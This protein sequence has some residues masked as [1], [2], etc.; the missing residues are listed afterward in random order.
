VAFAAV[1]LVEPVTDAYRWIAGLPW[2]SAGSVV[3]DPTELLA[4]PAVVVPWLVVTWSE[5]S[6]GGRASAPGRA[7]RPS[8]LAA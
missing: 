1:Q 4:L 2:G 6:S 7:D 5:R 8:G 3:A